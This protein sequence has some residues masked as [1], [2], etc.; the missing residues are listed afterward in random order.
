MRALQ[1]HPRF[2]IVKALSAVLLVAIGV[3]VGTMLDGG[4]ERRVDAVEIRMASTRHSLAAQHTALEDSRAR[5]E[6]AEAA[7][8]HAV[9]GLQAARHA[10]RRLSRDLTRARH[11]RRHRKRGAR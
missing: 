1:E 9:A 8:A 3:A 4:N 5:A 6:R 11:P 2:T 10:N 7:A